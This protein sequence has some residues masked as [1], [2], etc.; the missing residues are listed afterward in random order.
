MN[1]FLNLLFIDLSNL[2]ENGDRRTV[3]YGWFFFFA[4]KFPV[5]HSSLKKITLYFVIRMLYYPN[6]IFSPWEFRVAFPE[7]SQLRQSRAIHP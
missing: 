5:V 2:V 7:E 1:V 3:I 4:K 6:G